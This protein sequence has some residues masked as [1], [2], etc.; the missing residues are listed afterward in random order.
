MSRSEFTNEYFDTLFRDL[1]KNNVR[2]NLS[3]HDAEEYA[4]EA[5]TRLL[6]DAAK[7]SGKYNPDLFRRAS[8]V[9]NRNI[10]ST[11]QN[12]KKMMSRRNAGSFNDEQFSVQKH[13]SVEHTVMDNE[14]SNHLWSEVMK[15][16][17]KARQILIAL[18]AMDNDYRSV[19]EILN[20]KEPVVRTTAYRA[21]QR[22]KKNLKP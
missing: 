6:A 4:Q 9:T 12:R 18:A 3:I 8:F 2:N 17:Q 1:V 20:A 11:S 13:R 10:V 14:Q 15:L 19:A 5:I 7:H 21:R 16:P 22:I